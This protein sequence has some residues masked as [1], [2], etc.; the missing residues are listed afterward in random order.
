MNILIT[1]ANN[2]IAYDLI[3]FFSD[4]SSTSFFVIAKFST[5]S[6]VLLILLSSSLLYPGKSFLAALCSLN[7]CCGNFCIQFLYPHKT[8][9]SPSN[10]CLFKGLL[11]ML[12]IQEVRS[13]VLLLII[14]DLD[15]SVTQR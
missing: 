9:S 15:I 14:Q 7:H 2:Y 10:T 13:V 5:C 3:N 6:S 11:L 4:K 12:I 1:G 8:D